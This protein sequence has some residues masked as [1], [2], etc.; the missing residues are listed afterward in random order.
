MC[1]GFPNTFR[2]TE[3]VLTIM[4][5]SSSQFLCFFADSLHQT[6]AKYL[7]IFNVDMLGLVF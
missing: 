3:R 2:V 1:Q 5:A 7:E 6:T 4:T